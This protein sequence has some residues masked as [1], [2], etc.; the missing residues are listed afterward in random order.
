MNSELESSS[1]ALKTS[2]N[3]ILKKSQTE[4]FKKSFIRDPIID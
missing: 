2:N 4:I 3:E 1:R